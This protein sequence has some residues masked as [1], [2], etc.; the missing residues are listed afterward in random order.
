MSSTA[1]RS[2]SDRMSRRAALRTIAG[3]GAALLAF[4]TVG[5]A[6]AEHTS[7]L[8]T[9]S[10]N[11]NFRTGPGTDYRIVTVIPRGGTFTYNGTTKNDYASITYKGTQGWVY[12]S[13]VVPAGT[14]G[15]PEIVGEAKTVYNVNL[16]SGPSTGHQILRVVPAGAWVKISRTIENDF[17]YVVYDGQSG[18]VYDPYLTWPSD[19]QG[20]NYRTTTT[21]LNLR[22]EPSTS[23]KIMTVMPAGAR[24]QLLHTAAN[25]FGNVNYN[26][27]QGWAYLDYLK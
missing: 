10:V 1:F 16:R 6:T 7:Q 22:A 5:L 4:T 19:D 3:A 20:G 13:F 25:G 2:S 26:G 15:S 18:W 11:A 24:V 23:A 27:M 21:R 8:Y 14:S 9:V 12:A 17:R